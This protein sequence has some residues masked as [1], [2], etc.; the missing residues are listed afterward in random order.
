MPPS[1]FIQQGQSCDNGA[2]KGGFQVESRQQRGFL[3]NVVFGFN[4]RTVFDRIAMIAF[5]EMI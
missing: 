5:G 2:Q 1:P 4:P 3:S